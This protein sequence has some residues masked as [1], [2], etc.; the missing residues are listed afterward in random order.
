MAAY[1]LILLG[2]GGSASIEST[3]LFITAGSFE[4]A[5][6]PSYLNMINTP[7]GSLSKAS[8]VQH[9]S[10]TNAYSGSLSFDVHENAM[11]LFSTSKLLGRA[12]EFDVGINDGID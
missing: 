10:G 2:Y 9:A 8:R 12:Y 11:N 5:V 7:S 4:K 3:Q 6:T 1:Q